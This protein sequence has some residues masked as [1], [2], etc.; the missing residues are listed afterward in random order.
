MQAARLTGFR[1][2][3]LTEREDPTPL[4]GQV[5]VAMS[6]AYI[7]GSEVDAFADPE[8]WDAINAGQ[9][10]IPPIG[11]EGAGVI[12]AV[13]ADVDG[14][15]AGD[16]VA[17][18][19]EAGF[20]RREPYTAFADKV[21]VEARHCVPANAGNPWPGLMEPI[22]C[23]IN[24][25]DDVA[26]RPGDRVVVFGT[27]FMA[28]IAIQLVALTTPELLVVVGRRPDGLERARRLGATHTVNSRDEADV[29]EAVRGIVGPEGADSAMEI[30][31][32]SGP[33][34]QAAAVTRA[35]NADRHAGTLGILGYHRAG[36][37]DLALGPINGGAMR[38]VNG[39]NRV[40]GRTLQ[41]MARADRLVTRG[42]LPLDWVG[43]GL[44]TY[45][46]ARVGEAFEAA[47]RREHGFTKARITW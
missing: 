37:R 8:F 3:E 7:C 14:L 10:T 39:H 17:V 15:H 13:G 28:N 43:A 31:G 11:H 16:R 32:H 18:W 6:E 23:A 1:E 34:N 20:A 41:A 35:G 26:P 22:G 12:T 24:A 42:L 19:F 2:V 44:S 45:P 36:T 9:E 21:L 29:V 46:L 38:I 27:G 25:V 5:V 40:A 4:R 33:L 47:A 30:I